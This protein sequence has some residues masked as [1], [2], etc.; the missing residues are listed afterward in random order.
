MLTKIALAVTPIALAALVAIAWSNSHT[1]ALHE[2]DL[3]RLH[4]EVSH[5]RE[6]VEQK[7]LKKETP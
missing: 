3:I 1:L 7:L 4:D 5:L 6:L 2:R